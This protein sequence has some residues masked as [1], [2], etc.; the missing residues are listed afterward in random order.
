MLTKSELLPVAVVHL[1]WSFSYKH[2]CMLSE[3]WLYYVCSL[4]CFWETMCSLFKFFNCQMVSTFF[5]TT[6]LGNLDE[7]WPFPVLWPRLG[8]AGLLTY[9][10]QHFD[11]IIFNV[12]YSSTKIAS[13]P[14]DLLTTVFPKAHLTSHS[15][16]SAQG[17]WP[18]HHGYLF[19]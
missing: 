4:Y 18:Y 8:L 2:I 15:R 7:D 12:V 19:H 6:L 14:L 5:N 11:S 10:V 1:P 9:W 16:M 13:H 17:D 3:S